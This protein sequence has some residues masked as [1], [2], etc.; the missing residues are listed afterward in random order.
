MSRVIFPFKAINA[1]DL[2]EASIT[3]TASNIAHMNHV[4]YQAVCS[5]GGSPVG[6]LTIQ[7]SCDGVSY[8]TIS[9]TAITADGTYLVD[10]PFISGHWIRPVY[11]KTSGTGAITVTLVAKGND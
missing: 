7:E 11:T 1:G 4:A 9:T 2:S 10:L 6:S 3:G 5:G 8:A